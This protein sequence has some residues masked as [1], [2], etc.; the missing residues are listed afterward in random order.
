MPKRVSSQPAKTRGKRVRKA[1]TEEDV[2]R[3]A[4]FKDE[5]EQEERQSP[6]RK[7]Q[8]A[9]AKSAK[10]HDIKA[11]RQDDIECRLEK[12]GWTPEDMNF[13][14]LGCLNERGWLQLVSQTK[15]VTDRVWTSLKPKLITLLEANRKRRLDLERLKRRA[16]RQGRLSKLL[17]AIKIQDGFTVQFPAQHPCTFPAQHPV[18]S[19]SGSSPITASYEPPFPQIT[20]ALDCPIVMDCYETDRAAAEMETKFE[21]HREEIERYITEWKT[22]IQ[23]HCAK[24]ARQG[25]KITKRIIQSS[26]TASDNKSDPFAN[27]SDDLKR[28]LRADSFFMRQGPKIT[29]KIIQSSLTASDNK[30]DPFANLSDDLKRLL[31]ADSFFSTNGQLYSLRCITYD[32]VLIWNPEA[33]KAARELLACLGIPNPS[34]LEMTDKAVYT[35]GRC[36]DAEKKTWGEM[37]YHYVEEKQRYA[38]VQQDL[39][40]S[41]AGIIYN[42]VHDPKLRT[43]LPLVRYSGAQATDEL[44]QYECKV[45]ADALVLG[46]VITSEEKIMQH[47]AAVHGITGPIID[48]HYTPQITEESEPEP[49]PSESGCYDLDEFSEGEGGCDYARNRHR[50]YGYG[51]R[52]NKHHHYRPRC[53]Y[54][55][56]GE[57][58]WL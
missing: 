27:L 57:D 8:R 10:T 37:V 6:P 42:S 26:L 23:A 50:Y 18:V 21:Q 44:D 3:D 22:R 12:L 56:G 36:H 11:E 7:R 33:N 45:C 16:E 58:E 39:V 31:R 49:E 55:G 13:S 47:L 24:L 2:E 1:V 46:E 48:E 35:C 9:S 25:P 30:S 32:Y 5:S 52:R 20:Y 29:K 40:S 41:K 51:R 38:R 54:G 19:L 15:P 34:Y 43:K 17:D 4:D 14:Y 53:Y 28:L